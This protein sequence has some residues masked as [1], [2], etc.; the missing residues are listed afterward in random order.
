MTQTRKVQGVATKVRVVNDTTLVEYHDTVVVS[1]TKDK[2]VLD[3]GGWKTA[4]TKLRMNQTANE[5]N[6]GFQVYQDKKEWYVSIWKPGPD[7]QP[8]TVPFSDHMVIHRG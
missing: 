5:Y 3:S 4:T 6:L 8:Y 2:I 1:F 7:P